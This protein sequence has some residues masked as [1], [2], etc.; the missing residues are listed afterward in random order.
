MRPISAGGAADLPPA[1]KPS[2]SRAQ[3]G[4]ILVIFVLSIFVL[5]GFIALVI[6]VSWYRSNSLRVQRAADAAALAGAVDLPGNPG[7][8]S[9]HPLGTGIGDALAEASK[10]GYTP[11]S[12][13]IITA[14]QDSVAISGG[15]TNQMDVTISAPVNT[16][17]MRIFGIQTMQANRNSKAVFTLPVPM[18]SPENFFGVFGAVRNATFTQSGVT[19]TTNADLSGPGAPCANGIA[20]CFRDVGGQTLTP[21]GFWGTMNSEGAE[22]VNG[23]AFLPYYDTATSA[24]ALTCG[25]TPGLDACDDPTSYYNYAISMPPNTTGGKVYIFD[26]G[27]CATLNSSGTGDHWFE[28][29]TAISSWYELFDTHNTPYDISDDS[30]ITSSGSLFADQAASDSTMGGSSGSNECKQTNVP[31]GDGRD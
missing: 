16:F 8:T 19:T 20:T 15:N 13:V 28:G 27:F 31:Y 26:P 11:G 29:G 23:D 9:D 2:K 3:R 10:N 12:G 25:T 4:Q 14:Q 7:T 22:N 6:D 21:G 24:P 30:L 5:T 1:A 18:G 17:F